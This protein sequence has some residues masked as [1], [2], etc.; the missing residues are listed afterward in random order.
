[1]GETLYSS[2]IADIGH[3]RLMLMRYDIRH[4]QRA[5]HLCSRPTC[6]LNYSRNIKTP[7]TTARQVSESKANAKDW[8]AF[9]T[10][11]RDQNQG[12][13]RVLRSVQTSH[14]HS[15]NRWHHKWQLSLMKNGIARSDVNHLIS[16][17][18]MRLLW[19][20]TLSNWTWAERNSENNA[21]GSSIN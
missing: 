3:V 1:M 5:S 17:I 9:I 19:K 11:Y 4:C 12:H 10:E 15:S 18:R 16:G 6:V 8:A 2:V 13:K 7:I 20:K 21:S 14:N